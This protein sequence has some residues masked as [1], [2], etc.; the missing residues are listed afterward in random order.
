MIWSSYE[1]KCETPLPNE[2]HASDDDWDD[3][4]AVNDPASGKKLPNEGHASDDDWDD[5]E[6][7]NDPASGKKLPNEGHANLTKRL[8]ET[9]G[10][11]TAPTDQPIRV[12]G[13]FVKDIS[14]IYGSFSALDNEYPAM[15]ITIQGAPIFVQCVRFPDCSV[16]RHRATDEVW[17]EHPAVG[18]LWQ[19]RLRQYD[20]KCRTSTVHIHPMNYP[21]LSGT[22]VSNFDSL[23]Q[24]PD[25][26]ST[27]DGEYPYPVVLINL[28]GAGRL[29]LLGFWVHDGRAYPVEVVPVRDN[30]VIVRQAWREA[31][32]MP[33]FSAEGDVARRINQRVSK[34]WE[35]ELGVNS[36][37]GDKA[38]KARRSDGKKVL[39]RF[40]SE[41]PLGLSVGGTAPR[42][43]CFENYVD[44]THLFDDLAGGQ[45]GRSG[46]EASHPACDSHRAIGIRARRA[47]SKTPSGSA[48][49]QSDV[50]VQA[51]EETST[52]VPV[53]HADDIDA[54]TPERV[55]G[56]H[57]SV[58]A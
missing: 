39:V 2:V 1:T 22:D 10:L 52:I 23:R 25:D 40:N 56:S 28:S 21:S 31:K 6:A 3:Y 26:P 16:V 47:P 17:R 20:G 19:D 45:E 13:T 4:E 11:A 12:T 49:T 46:S 33:Y 30:A 5:Y 7:V 43:F 35:V 54:Q 48:S 42:G 15:G 58:T 36:R 9:V 44:W 37:T 8:M 38:I 57:Y 50:A 32:K 34:E 55:P 53:E 41:T 27:F 24:N 18:A 14:E 51:K 29:E